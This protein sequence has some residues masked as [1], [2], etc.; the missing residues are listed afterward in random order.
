[1]HKLHHNKYI[2]LDLITFSI[3][4]FNINVLIY[5]TD[6]TFWFRSIVSVKLHR[7]D[8][9]STQRKSFHIEF[10]YKKKTTLVKNNYYFQIAR[11]AASLSSSPSRQNHCQLENRVTLPI[12]NNSRRSFARLTKRDA[13]RYS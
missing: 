13:R 12:F 1:M 11:Y 4:Y 6:K 7:Y 2:R 8:L 3:I 9:Q 10:L 5:K